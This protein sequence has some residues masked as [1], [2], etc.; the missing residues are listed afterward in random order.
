LYNNFIEQYKWVENTN[1][2]KQLGNYQVYYQAGKNTFVNASINAYYTQLLTNGFTIKNPNLESVDRYKVT[3]LEGLFN[4]PEGLNSSIRYSQF[5]RQIVNS[6]LLVGDAFIEIS[7]DELFDERKI[8]NGF[9]FIPPELIRWYED[10]SQYGFV[11][12]EN[13]RFEPR[14]LIHIFDPPIRSD[15]KFGDSRIDTIGLALSLLFE[16]LKY[17]K[18]FFKSGGIDPNAIVTFDKEM[19]DTDF[20]NEVT[21]LS[22]QA[23]QDRRGTLALKGGTIQTI[24]NL[25]DAD[26]TNLIVLSRNI[27]LNGYNVP[28]SLAGIVETANLSANTIDSEMRLFKPFVGAVAESIEGA[29]NNALGRYGFSEVFEFNPVDLTDKLEEMNIRKMELETGLK[30]INEIRQEIGLEPVYWGDSPL[31]LM[32]NSEPAPEIDTGDQKLDEAF[33]LIRQ[34]ETDVYRTY[35]YLNGGLYG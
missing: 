12:N 20:M 31:V 13:L 4:A 8:I 33:N 29:F 22:A 19:T 18:D 24:S 27:I 25:K 30:S 14:D 7:Y 9:K 10:T 16:S 34:A 21:R 2:N 15:N 6:Y 17:N 35:D 26:F 5:L 3:Y 11:N 23:K 28:P 1:Q 32:D